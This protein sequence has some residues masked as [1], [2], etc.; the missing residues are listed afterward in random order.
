[1][2]CSDVPVRIPPVAVAK[3]LLKLVKMANS[4]EATEAVM[5]VVRFSPA[6]KTPEER[7]A[8]QICCEAS[9]LARQAFGGDF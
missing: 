2:F 5:R 9:K 6:A 1:G 7:E 4:I 8:K 3:D